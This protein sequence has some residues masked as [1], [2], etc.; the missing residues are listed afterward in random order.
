MLAL[1]FTLGADYFLILHNQHLP[2]VAV[3]CF[4]HAA[5]ILRALTAQNGKTPA[6]TLESVMPLGPASPLES[7]TPPESALPL[8]SAMPPESALPL[9]STMLPESVSPWAS[10]VSWIS[11]LSWVTWL[12]VLTAVIAGLFAIALASP[13]FDVIY[14]VT[15]LYALLFISNIYISA[16]Y[17]KRNRALVITGLLLF[18]ACDVCVLIF[19]MPVYMGAPLWLRNIY[20]LIWVFYLPSQLLLAVSAVDYSRIN[21]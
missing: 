4:A 13:L 16:R 10:V 2:G 9:E 14:L 17:L 6:T 15:G 20:P 8:E 19:N 12:A 7:A 3:F 18:A 21:A 11:T 5:Y 1:G